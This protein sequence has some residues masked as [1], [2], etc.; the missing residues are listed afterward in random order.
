M[1]RDELTALVEAYFARV[2]AMDL[3]GTLALLTPDCVFRIVTGG[4]EHR[5]RDTGVRTMFERLFAG[6]RSVWHGDF[7]H[8][9]DSEADAVATRFRVVNVDRVGRRSE[10]ENCNFFRVAE[11]RFASATIYMSGENTLT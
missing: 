6:H 11:G 4:V 1:T 5:G 9:A 10:L 2:D 3:D 8:V 7:H